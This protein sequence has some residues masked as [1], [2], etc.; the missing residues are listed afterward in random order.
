M[1]EGKEEARS[2]YGF[3]ALFWIAISKIHL[4]LPEVGMVSQQFLGSYFPNP[5]CSQEDADSYDISKHPVMSTKDG[6]NRVGC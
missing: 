5:L 3:R 6:H 4:R 1:S 2:Q